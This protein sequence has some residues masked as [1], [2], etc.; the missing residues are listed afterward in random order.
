MKQLYIITFSE[1]EIIKILWNF[2]HD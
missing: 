2:S 1:L